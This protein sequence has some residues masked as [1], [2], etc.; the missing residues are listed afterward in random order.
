MLLARLD[1]GA[2]GLVL[3]HE[4]DGRLLP[5]AASLGAFRDI[6]GDGAACIDSA[7][8]HG[9]D[10]TVLI[11]QWETVRGPLAAMANYALSSDDRFPTRPIAECRLGPALPTLST[12]IF[13]LGGNFGKHLLDASTSLHG[14]VRAREIMEDRRRIGPWG[15]HALPETVVGHEHSI[16]SPPGL[17]KLDYEGEVAVVLRSGGRGLRA[18]DVRFWGV[19]GFNDF[20]LRDTLFQ[21]GNPYD[22]GS[23]SWTLQKNF[24][25]GSSCGPWIAVDEHRDV[26]AVR[27]TLRVNGEVRQTGSTSEMIFSFAETAEHLSRFL[28]LR[29]GDVIAS[30][31]PAGTAMESG[32]DGRFLAPGDETNLEVE[33]VGVLRNRIA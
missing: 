20:S 14:E 21:I 26:D 25:R 33:G 28:T 8:R 29:P 7:L 16:A 27:M 12:R 5:V 2:L 17:T 24:D 6:D 1:G 31:T 32:I 10:W 11:E 23:L 22:R 3:A 18:G 9:D 15:F 13:A 19:T 30:G 4:T